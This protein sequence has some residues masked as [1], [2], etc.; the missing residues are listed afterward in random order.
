MKLLKKDGVQWLIFEHFAKYDFVVHG[1]STRIGGVS[2]PPFITLNLAFHVGDDPKAVI[3]NRKR[4]CQVLGLQLKDLTAG[5]QVHGD[6]IRVVTGKDRGSGA[7][8]YDTAFPC[9]DGF[10][11]NEPGVVLSSYYADCVPLYILDPIQKAVGLAHAGW[12]GTV[13]RIG[14]RIIEAMSKNFGTRA[15]DCLI[16][17]GPSIGPCCYEVDEHVINPLRVEF[18][19]WEELVEVKENGRWNL[20]LWEIN[21]RVFIETGVKPEQIET[22]GLCTSC[23]TDLFFSYRAEG[24][25]TGRMASIIMLKDN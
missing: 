6:K 18:P 23:R 25:K 14:A 21:R 12:K 17:I 24:G 7:F 20:N 15:E 1:F 4:F 9:T 2:N 11:T 5:E 19:Y 10:I 3:E 13:K 16:G 8:E 22:S